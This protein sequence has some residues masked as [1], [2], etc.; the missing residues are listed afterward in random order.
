MHKR[1]LLAAL[2]ALVSLAPAAADGPARLAPFTLQ[3]FRGKS[4]TLDD[5]KDQQLLVVAFLGTECPLAKLYGPRLAKLHAEYA[6]KGVGF[7][8]LDSNAQDAVTALAAY[9]RL[10]NVTFPLLK[11]LNNRV[12]DQLGA[13]R[14]PEVFVLDRERKV[15]YH[16]RVDDQYGI[17]F[18]RDEPRRRDLAAALDELLAGKPVSV[19]QTEATGC[20]IGRVQAAKAGAAVTYTQHVAPLLNRRCVECHREGDI[21]PF[22][23]TEYQQVAGWAAMIREVVDE[24]RM[25]P[26]HADPRHG[27]F[28]NDRRLTD[29]EKDLIRQWVAAGAPEGDPQARPPAPAFGIG[30]TLPRQPDKVV[31]MAAKPYD[32]PA[33]GAV[34]YQYFLA[35]AGLTEDKWVEG[36]EVLPGN[37]AV[38]HHIIVFAQKPG[39]KEGAEL[40]SGGVDGYLAAYVPGLRALPY[41]AGMAKKVAAG[42]KL[43][44]QIHYTPNG[45]KQQDLSKVGLLFADPAKVQYQVRTTSSAQRF[46]NIPPMA[47]NHKV[48]ARGRTLTRDSLLLGMMPHMH[49]R[50]KAFF[51]E[52]VYPDGKAETLLDVPHF[53]FNWQ[54]SYRLAEPKKLPAGTRIH[55]IAHFDNSPGNLSNPDPSK[56]VRWGDQTWNEMMIGYFDVATP[57]AAGDDEAEDKVVIPKEGVPIPERFKAALQQYDKNK[58][59]RLTEDEIDA[60]PQPLKDRVL[61]FLRLQP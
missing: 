31:P 27:H 52:A 57:R 3:D 44:F 14:T 60:M 41:P 51:Y 56:A 29:A 30:W 32:V 54:T 23:L 8:G 2:A 5:F 38:V 12:A 48:E 13:Q 45:S 1:L 35:D 20:L 21:A 7:V 49:L 53:D 15:R 47:D 22:P 4:W 17:G 26:W 16:G 59:G 42:S 34:K 58:D 24:G 10:H 43:I 33:E 11:D 61:L 36:V 37:R 46:I 19:P 6:P 28:V 40:L 9:A 39:G 55:C 18:S 50:G 25:P